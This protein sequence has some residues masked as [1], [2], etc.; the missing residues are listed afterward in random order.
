MSPSRELSSTK[1]KK[2]FIH[3]EIRFIRNQ[4]LLSH[5]K[6]TRKET[7]LFETVKQQEINDLNKYDTV[8]TLTD[9]DKNILSSNNVKSDIV[10]SP[11]AVNTAVKNYNGWNNHIVF[12][13]GYGHKPNAEG[14]DW[15]INNVASA[16]DWTK[17]NQVEL[18]MIGN[19]WPASVIQHYKESTKLPITYHGFVEDLSSVAYGAIMIVPILTG[20]RHAH[21]DTRSGIARNAVH[22]YLC[23][24]GGSQFQGQR[25]ML[26]R[27]HAGRMERQ[28][29]ASDV[30]RGTAQTIHVESTGNLSR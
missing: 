19:G 6:L 14:L 2:I 18:H 25:L 9:T 17:Y 11:A 28:A 8:V 7:K 15:F 21:E 5:I 26:H 16:I 29:G 22:N 12:L 20:S 23:R 3:H 30:M 1:Y 4:R 13:G 27:R 24:S 10:V